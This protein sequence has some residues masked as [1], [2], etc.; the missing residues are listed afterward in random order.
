MYDKGV[1]NRQ[2]GPKHTMRFSSAKT[3]GHDA[4]F[5]CAFRNWHAASNCNRLHGYALMVRVEF[6]ANALDYRSWVMD[7][8]DV[9]R[10]VKPVLTNTF[11][12]TVIMA[13]DDPQKDWYEWGARTKLLR[14][15][16]V[17]HVSVEAFAA[18]AHESV[19]L[20]LQGSQYHPRVTCSRVDVWE[21]VGNQAS[22]IDHI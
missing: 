2:Q 12:H 11:D 7:F 17:E 6:S 10:D 8:G 3:F 5:S 16:T 22:V 9:V 18:L 21:H 1:S 15:I 20:W 13:A 4:G 19:R 14:L